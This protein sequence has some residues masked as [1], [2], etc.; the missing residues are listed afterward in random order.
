MHAL[1]TWGSG[2]AEARLGQAETVVMHPA[3][4]QRAACAD[5]VRWLLQPNPRGRPVSMEEALTHAFFQ[6]NLQ[7]RRFVPVLPGIF[8]SHFQQSGGG[9]SVRTLTNYIEQEAPS[10][11]EGGIW[12]D[13]NASQLTEEGMLLGVREKEVF[14]LF[15]TK[16]IFERWFVTHVELMEAV[17]TGKPIVLVHEVDPAKGGHPSFNDYV[18][19]FEALARCT[20]DKCKAVGG[21]AFWRGARLFEQSTSVECYLDG[22]FA[23][24]TARLVLKRCGY[25]ERLAAQ[26]KFVPVATA[27]RTARVVLVHAAADAR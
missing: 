19:E 27:V 12:L 2:S 7:G 24:A 4:E 17:R 5:L 20:C 6:D 13:M 22:P 9:S 25:E 8:M 26:P 21:G 3:A 23:S 10:L 15:L 11:A 18:V 14:L 1:A 16:G